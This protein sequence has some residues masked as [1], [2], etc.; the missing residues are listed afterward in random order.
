MLFRKGLGVGLMVSA[1]VLR[2]FGFDMEIRG[3][4][5][6]EINITREGKRSVDGEAA[7]YIYI[8]SVKQ[9]IVGYLFVC[10]LNYG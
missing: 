10:Y 7:I 6:S 2:A 3:E 5:L 8:S 9:S 4:D 1:M